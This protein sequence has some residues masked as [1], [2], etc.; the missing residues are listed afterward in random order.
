MWQVVKAAVV[1]THTI[2]HISDTL[3]A[4][5]NRTVINRTVTELV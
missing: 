3:V 2:A 1:H 5:D 4:W